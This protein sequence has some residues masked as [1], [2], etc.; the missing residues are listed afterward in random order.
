V[1]RFLSAFRFWFVALALVFTVAGGPAAVADTVQVLSISPNSG[2]A[3]GNNPI[4]IT[5]TGF[6]SLNEILIGGFFVYATSDNGTSISFD[7]PSRNYL[8]GPTD[9]T[10]NAQGNGMTTVRRG[11]T[12]IAA[13][14]IT[15]VDTSAGPVAGGTPVK[16]TGTNFTGAT[17]I[18][19]A[20]APPVS[21][22]VVNDTEISAVTPAHAAGSA[23]IT[24]TTPGGTGTLANGFTYVLPPS[25]GSVSPDSGS[26]YS[27]TTVTITGTNFSGAT[28]VKFG[29]DDASSF[30]VNSPTSITAKTAGGTGIVNVSVTTAGGT[31]SSGQFTYLGPPS[32]RGIDTAT[33]PTAGGTSVTINGSNFT[34]SSSVKFGTADA[35]SVTFVDATQLKVVSPAHEAGMVLIA[36]K[37]GGGNAT[38]TGFTYGDTPTIT[39]V[40]PTAGPT[41]GGNTVIITG[42]GFSAAETTDAVKFG[43]VTASYTVESDSTI[44]ATAPQLGAGTYDIT[45]RTPVGTSAASAADQYNSVAAPT[46]TS[47]DKIIGTT[48]GGTQVVI[49]GTGFSAAEQTG[50]VKF[51]TAV[52]NYTINSNTQITAWSPSGSAGTVDV[53]V[54]TPGGTSDTSSNA[55]FTFVAAPT[56][57]Y[58]DPV[59]GPTAG[60]ATVTLSGSNFTP[61]ATVTFSGTPVS[62]TVNSATS[63]TVTTP[64]RTLGG[65][66]VIVTTP[67]GSASASYTYAPPPVINSISPASG[68]TAGGTDITLDGSYFLY[69]SGVTID[70][71]SVPFTLNGSSTIK[72]RTPAHSAGPVDIV[73][74][75]LGGTSAASRDFTYAT[76]L[77][78]TDVAPAAGPTAGGGDVVITGTG[79]SNAPATGAVKFGNAA[80]SY[81]INS[82]T[83]ITAVAPAHAAGAVDVAVTISGNTGT[84]VNGY[85]FAAP[86]TISAVRPA[87]GSTAGRQLVT[88]TGTNLTG[89]TSVKFGGQAGT[90]VTVVSATKLTVTTP[91]HAEGSV[92]VAVA[93]SGGSVT[94]SDAYDYAASAP[95]ISAV[96]PATGSTTGGQLVTISGT[97]LTGATSVKFG[98]TAATAVTVV[99]ARKITATAPAH[100]TGIVSMSVTTPDGSA[101]RA[102]AY[103]YSTGG[104]AFSPASG[105]LANG[106]TGKDY[107]QTIKVSGGSAPYAYTVMGT[108]PPGLA[109][110]ST[111]GIIAGS[112]TKPGTYN[113]YVLATDALRATDSAAYSIT[114]KAANLVFSPPVGALPAG[115]V[116]KAYRRTIT[117]SGGS[118]PYAYSA[119]GSLPPGLSLDA[120]TGTISGKPTEAGTYKFTVKAVDAD[121]VASSVAY[122]IVIAAPKANFVFTPRG[123]AL[124]KAMA[125]EDYSA[126][127]S[128][129]GGKAPLVYQLGSGKLPSGLTLNVS[130]GELTGPLSKKAEGSYAFSIQVRD[131]NGATGSA[132]FTLKVIPRAIT[133]ANKSQTVP[134][135]GTPVDVHLDKDATGGPFSSADVVY[136]D[137]PNA[138]TATITGGQAAQ[139]GPASLPKGWYL[140]F[141][142][143]PSFGGQARVGFKLK[144]GLGSSNTGIVTYVLSA[145]VDK[146]AAEIDQAV[147]SFVQTRQNLISSTIKVPGLLERR[148]MEQSTEAVTSRLTP[149]EQGMTANVST[150]LAQLESARDSADGVSGGYASP[151]NIWMD[152]AFLAFNDDNENGGRWGNFTML[153]LGTDYLVSDKLLVGVSF[154][155]DHMTDPTDGD[156]DLKGNGW[157]AGP[158]ASVEIG[159]NVFWNASLL[160]GGSANDIDTDFWSGSFDT[161]RWL[162]DTSIEGQWK[163][164]PSTTLS[165][166]L[167]VLYF[168]EKVEDYTVGND[169]GDTIA[170]KGF[171]EEQFR[172]SLGAEIARSFTLEGGAKLTPKLGL[173]GGFSSLDGSGAFGSVTAGLSLQTTDLWM[174]D[175]SLLLDIEGDG[176]RSVGAKIGASKRF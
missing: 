109:L 151:F 127:I 21:P 35:T 31:S 1:S 118:A 20:G 166:K 150:S 96:T 129:K 170:M 2:P 157:L 113:F 32:I 110:N 108:L 19:F 176:Q 175:A 71:V 106:T 77:S 57:N 59:A 60:G 105:K 145:D 44:K 147:H 174:I 69:A 46:V 22:T 136:V 152:G 17:S 116:G 165:P 84:L 61:D 119:K 64:A 51:G 63:I 171:D 102:E 42:T 37:T 100:A 33:G 115:T 114:V 76:A 75:T 146:V 39:E 18:T 123:G 163:L 15:G 120:E 161:T 80:A 36:V 89:A 49:K 142:P 72:L 153:N 79:F 40:A 131:A 30:T 172:V 83:K 93:T 112:P 45:V 81:T 144:S 54:K 70:G 130:T 47:I 156:A 134:A 98:N 159:R 38:F 50:A 126:G 164:D 41:A 137:P 87:A 29:N 65:V 125:G 138:G 5:G 168:S 158:Y 111:T 43:A 28:A 13:P 48:A 9:I 11:Y 7:V 74:T 149:S 88:I 128:A 26:G 58:V 107:S 25:I 82:D 23:A 3:T 12:F 92:D 155:Y 8:P 103:T 62:A 14:T 90:G 101:I 94:L 124:P 97:N 91:A 154:H 140:H 10:V 6:S 95:T 167:R 53:T 117:A 133:V 99:S 34:S 135:G 141:V 132:A 160:Y 148:R 143:N 122:S 169:A 27:E 104:I 56:L 173:T 52:A 73:V 139:A 78:V 67:G 121:G 86:P 68:S 4:T 66:S 24:V 85:T 16:I 162:A 55:R